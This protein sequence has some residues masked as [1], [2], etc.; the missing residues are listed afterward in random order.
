MLINYKIK[1]ENFFA[2]ERFT[3]FEGDEL[4][5]LA[6]MSLCTNG[7]ISSGLSLG[8]WGAFLGAYAKRNPVVVPKKWIKIPDSQSLLPEEWITISV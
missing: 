8:W 6:L 5:T 1:S 2:N 4:E 7:T 3:I